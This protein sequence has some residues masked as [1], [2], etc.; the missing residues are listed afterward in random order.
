MSDDAIQA[1]KEKID[2]VEVIGE[3][4]ELTRR[5]Q[6]Y[7]GL[8]PF[9]DERTPS[10]SI[11][12]ERRI[13]KCFGCQ[14]SGDVFSFLQ[15]IENHSFTDVLYQLG[16]IA[17]VS[18]PKREAIKIDVNSNRFLDLLRNATGYFF[19][20]LRGTKGARA[21]SYLSDRSLNTDILDSFGIGYALPETTALKSHINTCGF[22]DDELRSLGLIQTSQR[23]G[24]PFDLFRDRIIFP[25]LSVTGKVVGFG[26]RLRVE[27]EETPKYINSPKSK[28]FDKS[29]VLYGMYMAKEHIKSVGSLVLVEG[30]TD[31][32]AYNQAGVFNVAAPCGTGLT[33]EQA[34]LISRYTDRVSIC[35]D[36]DKAGAKA[37]TSWSQLLLKEGIQVD[38]VPLPAGYD[39]DL[40]RRKFGDTDLQRTISN[41]KTVLDIVIEASTDGRQALDSCRSIIESIKDP[42]TREQYIV[43]TASRLALPKASVSSLIKSKSICSSI[44]YTPEVTRKKTINPDQKEQLLLHMMFSD[45][46]F[47]ETSID[48]LEETD[49]RTTIGRQAFSDLKGI[50]AHEQDKLSPEVGEFF[51]RMSAT[52]GETA[53]VPNVN[54]LLLVFKRTK[55][56]EEKDRI[57]RR[58]TLSSLGNGESEDWEKLQSITRSEV[59]LRQRLASIGG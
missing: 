57:K 1:I 31:V 40:F 7:I 23:D 44:A 46:D 22:T 27:R 54:E 48:V 16:E 34:R 3:Y 42:Y 45:K 5:G 52:W 49:F 12:P 38:V 43:Q 2:I 18:L 10:F 25:I 33:P 37:I 21:F 41:R 59:D 51:D 55:L 58:I 35:T 6:S 39:P 11:H 26:G 28:I 8:C 32:L 30:N 29:N 15:E 50:F 13:F 4:V 14:K 9:H 36:A 17:Q 53:P 19:E 47:M 56:R 24:R 20:N